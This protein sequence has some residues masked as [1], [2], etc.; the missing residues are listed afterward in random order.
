MTISPTVPDAITSFLIHRRLKNLSPATLRLYERRLLFWQ[1]WR[2][3]RTLPVDLAG[4]GIDELR[5]Y[6]LYLLHEHVPHQ[7]NPCRPP[8]HQGMAASSVQSDWRILRTFWN[9]LKTDESLTAAQETFFTRNRIP[10]PQVAEEIRPTCPPETITALLDACA[11]AEAEVEWRNKAIIL[12]L[13]ESGMRVGEL[14]GVRGLRDQDVSLGDRWAQVRGK[15]RNRRWV[16]WGDDAAHAVETY[17]AY[18]RGT[19]GGSRPLIR[20]TSVVNDGQAFSPD[21]VRSLFKRLAARAEMTLPAGAPV[22]SLRHGYAHACLDAGMDGLHLQQLL[23]HT[24]IATTQ[25]Y[26]REHPDQLKRV[27]D[28]Y[29]RRKRP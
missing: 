26:T 21:A 6:L 22:H 4:V 15:G 7:T 18:R 14:C 8:A 20:G 10:C 3:Q 28:R 9:Y 5:Q 16:Y 17:L 19:W 25:R 13:A 1:A 27:Y 23:G 24:D 12:L 29:Y 2:M 11:G